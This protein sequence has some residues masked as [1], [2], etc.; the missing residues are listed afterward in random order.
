MLYNL[1]NREEYSKAENQF[2]SFMVDFA[3]PEDV[4]S[5]ITLV[6]SD[7]KDDNKLAKLEL[8]VEKIQALQNENYEQ[9]EIIKKKME[10]L[11]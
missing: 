8:I 11:K 4:E 5:I 9:L 3:Y 1:G 6:K 10:K 2:K 7:L